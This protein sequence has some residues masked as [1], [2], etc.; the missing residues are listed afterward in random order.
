MSVI[1]NFITSGSINVATDLLA[2]KN[3]F[4]QV[5]VQN[6]HASADLYV[7]VDADAVSTG[8]IAGA[9]IPAKGSLQI[10]VQGRRVSVASGT[11]SVPVAYYDHVD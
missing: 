7:N 9:I 4:G 1:T 2:N 8:T 11:A 3:L 6:L 10:P 5:I